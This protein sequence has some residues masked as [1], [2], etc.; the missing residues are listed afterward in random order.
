MAVTLGL[1]LLVI[2]AGYKVGVLPVVVGLFLLGF[3]NGAWDVAMNV[4]GAL[5]ER[6]LG[7]AIMAR[8]HAGF[9][10]GTVAGALVGAVMVA[11]RVPVTAHLA[12][13][14]LVIGVAVPVGVRRFIADHADPEAEHS[15]GPHP[16]AAWRE[17]RTLLVGL[18]VLAFAFGE[19]TG[20]DWISVALIGGYH[21]SAALGTLGFAVF[22]VAMT[23]G[24]WV[25]PSLLDQY[26]RVPVIRVLAGAGAVG[27]GMFVFGGV[28]AV[29]FIG[30]LLW[31]AGVSLGFPVGMSAAADDAAK[32]AA[33]VSVVASIGYCA[34]LGGPPLIGFLGQQF[35]VLHAVTAVGVLLALA[36]V[37]AGAVRPLPR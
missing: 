2:A 36:T 5:V 28:T 18:F 26:G 33:R 32:A 13:V 12:A 8:F 22:L 7:K 25:G 31:G 20:N 4:Q 3:A 24:R 1:A 30:V 10:L 21:T 34:F 35:S 17:P 27:L 15:A 11:L 6:E 23:A 16:L 19:G 14:G 9:S 37:I 29:A